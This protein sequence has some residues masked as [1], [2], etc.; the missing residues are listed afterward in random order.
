MKDCPKCG[1]EDI[2]H[3]SEEEWQCKFCLEHFSDGTE[4]N[5]GDDKYYK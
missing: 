3:I 5:H 4:W 2:K 1:S